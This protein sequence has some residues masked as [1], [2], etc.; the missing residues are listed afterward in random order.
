MV[1]KR[2]E[3]LTKWYLKRNKLR[4]IE[5]KRFNL[6]NNVKVD[7]FTFGGHY[8]YVSEITPF[9]TI[10]ANNELFYKY[11]KNVQNY[12]ISHEYGHIR[13]PI[14]RQLLFTLILLCASFLQF[15]GFILLMFSL[16]LI[17]P[18][19]Y[20]EFS[21][22]YIR[23]FTFCGLL[24]FIIGLFCKWLSELDADFYAI[25]LCG[26]DEIIAARN[27]IEQKEGKISIKTKILRYS[28]RMPPKLTFYLYRLKIILYQIFN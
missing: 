10:V 3:L 15:I 5:I 9:S 22:L 24:L 2:Q 4:L 21:I 18:L 25:K 14:F 27:E 26:L 28:S 7:V 19:I 16:I 13:F 17:I 11:S 12:F 8:R 1:H 23:D 20:Y 6:K